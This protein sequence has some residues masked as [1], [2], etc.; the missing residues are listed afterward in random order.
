[1][2]AALQRATQGFAAVAVA[3]TVV[4][5]GATVY[6]SRQPVPPPTPTAVAQGMQSLPRPFVTPPGSVPGPG[7]PDLSRTE[8]PGGATLPAAVLRAYRNAEVRLAQALPG[9]RLTWPVLAGIGQV[10]SGQARGGALAADGTTVQPIIGPALNGK[11]FAPIRDTDAG[12]LDGDTRWDRAVGPMQFIPSTWAVWGT[13][14]ND[15]RSASP[16]NMYDAALTAGRYLC[17][18]G[19]NLSEAGDLRKALLSYN[20]SGAY[21]DTVLGWIARYAG[22]PGPESSPDPDPSP[23]PSPSASEPPPSPSASTKNPPPADVSP[24]PSPSRPGPDKDAPEP[25]PSV[26]P[27]PSTQDPAA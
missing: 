18:G 16:H 8:L 2:A 9:C 21:A 5:V 3:A 27:S 12:R 25:P 19:R 10:E 6:E 26:S 13:D 20:Q 23:S 15:D 7:A 24:S 22:M 1:M 17:A 11:G 14:G 4:T